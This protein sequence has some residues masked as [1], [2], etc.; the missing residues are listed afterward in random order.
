MT[1]NHEND[2]QGRGDL[3]VTRVPL[4]QGLRHDDQV[5][6][7]GVARPIHLDSGEQL[8]DPTTGD[9]QLLVM[10]TGTVKI[11]RVDS[12]GREQILRVLGPGDFVGESAFLTGHRPDHFATAVEP[13]S[14]CAFRHA[15]LGQ[16]VRAHPSIGLRML[17][18]VSG[19][20]QDA[21]ARLASVISGDVSSR[22][23]NYLL[24]LNGSFSDGAMTVELP[25]AKKDIASL[26]D[27]T[28]ES[29]SRQLRRLRES[30]VVAEHGAR[31]L[32]LHDIDALTN[33][34]ERG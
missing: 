25:L 23:A 17:R 33:L 19:R 29:L 1:Q 18:D 9:S 12:E 28:P 6:V 5:D 11:S 4:F 20:L 32:V 30:G 8:Y 3:C 13:A 10:H 7:A 26:L 34:A 14:M 2:Q 22:L 31:H 27:T 15:D 21:E 24:S 16:L